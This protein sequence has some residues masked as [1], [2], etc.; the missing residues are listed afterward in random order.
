MKR[1]LQKQIRAFKLSWEKYPAA[2]YGTYFA[3]TFALLT[4]V[5]S[6]NFIPNPF[7]PE[8]GKQSPI[9]IQA[10]NNIDV[11][12]KAATEETIQKKEYSIP[13]TYIID[14]RKTQQSLEELHQVFDNVRSIQGQR[15]SGDRRLVVLRKT[16]PFPISERTMLTL[17]NASPRTLNLLQTQSDYILKKVLK[18]GVR[19]NSVPEARID[20]ERL[21]KTL[22]WPEEN[23]DA[24]TELAQEAL[25]PNESPDW[26]SIDKQRAQI[27]KHYREEPITRRIEKGSVVVAKGETITEEKMDILKKLGYFSSSPTNSTVFSM[28][29]LSFLLLGLSI[30]FLIQHYPELLKKE[31]HLILL[32]VILI[33]TLM[34]AK[35]LIPVSGYLAPVAIASILIAILFDGRLSLFET[36]L[37][38][39]M[40]GLLTNEIR[41]VV[42]AFVG[43]SVAIFTVSRDSNRFH[44]TGAG[45]L[46]AIGNIVTIACFS[47]LGEQSLAQFGYDALIG[48]VNGLL[49]AWL[50]IGILPSLE[51]LSGVTTSFR[52]MELADPNAPILKQFLVE[53]PGS[54]HH[55]ILVANL[56]ENAAL[57]VKANALLVRVGAY[58]HDI[59]KMRRPYFFIE[60]QMGGENPH[61]K[62]NPTLST[63]IVTAHTKDGYEMA[64]AHKLPKEIQD[65]ISQHHGTRPVN[66][67]YHQAILKEG[68]DRVN[69]DDFRH[70]GPKPQSREAAIL[71]LS[72]VVEAATRSLAKPT[73]SKIEQTVRE[74][75]RGAQ[76]DGQ[77]D[78]C[79]LSFKELNILI[80]TYIRLLTGMY[81]HRIEY[82]DMTKF[83]PKEHKG[84]VLRI[85]NL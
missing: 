81:H 1:W 2:R 60:N 66:Y 57:A 12:D 13:L 15:M 9:E 16:I 64:K 76:L 58:Y 31:K 25:T 51:Q 8:L 36:A 44:L 29:I 71:M 11:A 35:L 68:A 53:C 61:D 5:L 22:P 63:L 72:D 18:Q 4:F 40:I 14:P 43:G 24:I 32:A 54:Y 23:A 82:P 6:A 77:L 47:M 28:A 59:G 17:L 56:A 73:P 84:Q 10:Q 48:G 79:E 7:R 20:I 26:A 45:F 19:D 65:I 70:E 62:L 75:I 85:G 37:L 46:V 74:V 83:E 49:S 41:D 67:F 50:A 38:S 30:F 55:S 3:V 27:E 52:L 39:L 34:I 69:R 33:I 80:A 78:E 21:A 42:V